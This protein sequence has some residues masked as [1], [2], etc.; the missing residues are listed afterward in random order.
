[1]RESTAVVDLNL[2]RRSDLFTPR[3]VQEGDMATVPADLLEFTTA[4]RYASGR[5]EGPVTVRLPRALADLG[6]V[7]RA[8]M[9]YACT[10]YATG[11]ADEHGAVTFTLHDLGRWVG[12]KRPNA[13]QY[14]R[15]ERAVEAIA[16]VRFT[17]WADYLQA[18]ASPKRGARGGAN[19]ER[20][21]I[22]SIFG[23]VDEADIETR[24]RAASRRQAEHLP[25]N[26]QRRITLWLNRR[27]R[28]ALDNGPSVRLPH[29]ALRRLGL[30]HHLA[31]HLYFLI[32]SKR[33]GNRPVELSSSVVEQV[34]RPTTAWRRNLRHRTEAAC[35]LICSA[36]PG[37][38]VEVT[39]AAGGGW[40]VVAR[41]A[42][43]GDPNSSAFG[44]QATVIRGPSNAHSG[45]EQQSFGVCATEGS[46]QPK[47]ATARRTRPGHRA[48]RALRA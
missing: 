43:D 18:S 19:Y 37:W 1:M 48:S 6:S 28:Q 17:Q 25:A 27:F 13:T 20:V 38:K 4:V 42:D 31:L 34:V 2:A 23:F 15:L 44:V 16:S 8:V 14:D 5:A 41:H 22:T 24:E 35:R 32:A 36:D 10:R 47:S 46:P 7:E 9:V 11:A 33:A 30:Q 3:G 21:H 40:K 12:W 45:S 39:D 29:E 26:A